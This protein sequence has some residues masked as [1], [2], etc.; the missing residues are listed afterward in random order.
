MSGH[1]TPM[2]PDV[3]HTHVPNQTLKNI[4]VW[5]VDEGVLPPVTPIN[6]YLG[7]GR[8]KLVTF[9]MPNHI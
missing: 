9:Y 4:K 7:E 3:M 5:C 6:P 2:S 1:K 8:K